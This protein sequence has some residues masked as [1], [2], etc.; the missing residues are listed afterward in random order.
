MVEAAEVGPRKVE[1]RQASGSF[2]AG[3]WLF[4]SSCLVL[5]GLHLPILVFG[6]GRP[7]DSSI[8]HEPAGEDGRQRDVFPLPLLEVSQDPVSSV[9]RSVQQRIHLKRQLALRANKA[10]F[11]VNLLFHG[12]NSFK[13][14]KPVRNLQT[15][16]LVQRDAILGIMEHVRDLGP[17]I[18]ACRSE[19][20]K[21]LRASEPPGY[22]VPD[23]SSGST[24]PM[25]LDALSLPSRGSAGVDLV[26]A[27]AEPVRSMVADFENYMLADS[28][29]WSPLTDSVNAMRPYNDPLLEQ[30]SSYLAFLTRLFKGGVLGFSD[31]CK[32]RVGAFCV[33][34]KPKVVDAVK[35][36]RQRLVLDCRQTNLLFK[37]PPQTHLGSL[38]SLA[39][40][41][42]ADGCTLHVAGADIRDCFYAVNMDQG[43]QQYFGLAFDISDDELFR[44]TGGVFTGGSGC[45]VPVIKVLPMGFSWSFYLV[46]QLHTENALNALGLDEKHLFLEGRPAPS[47]RDDNL[48][49]M[50]YC[51]NIHSICT[52]PSRCQE[53]KDSMVAA[54]EDIGFELHEHMEASPVFETL[55]GVI[56]G[57]K[58]KVSSTKKR[59]WQLIF[60]FET[61]SNIVV[62]AKTIQRLLGH[63]MV[64]SVL[65]RNGMSVFRKLYDFVAAEGP[66]RKLSPSERQECI[67][68][69]GIVPLLVANLRRPW[70]DII[71]CTDASPFGYG[72]CEQRVS[73]DLARSHGRWL[74]RWRFK[75]LP[76]SEWKPRIRSQGWDPLGDIRTVAGDVFPREDLEEEYIA[77]VDFPEI[78][79]HLMDPKLWSTVKLGKWAHTSEHI[80]LKEARALLLAVRRLSRNS[81]H[82]GRRHLFLVDNLA[83]CFSVA[84]GRAHSYD[85]LRVIQK[86]SAISLACQLTIRTRWVRS[87][88]NV[89]DGPS[90]GFIKPGAAPSCEQ[91]EVDIF[92]GESH[93][94]EASASSNWGSAEEFQGTQ[95]CSEV[96][97]SVNQ[98]NPCSNLSWSRPE[99]SYQGQKV[100]AGS[101]HPRF[102]GH[103]GSEEH[104][105]RV[106]DQ[107]REQREQQSVLHLLPQVRG[108]LEGER[109]P[110][111]TSQR[112]GR[113]GSSRLHGCAVLRQK[114][115]FSGRENFSCRRILQF[116]V[117][118]KHGTKQ[119]SF[120]GLEK[121]YA[122]SKSVAPPSCDDDGN[123]HEVG[124]KGF[125]GHGNHGDR[126]LRPLSPS[127]RGLEPEGQKCD[128]PSEICRGAIQAGHSGGEGFRDR[129]PR[130]GRRVRQFAENRQ[131]T[132]H[133]DWRVPSAEGQRGQRSRCHDFQLH[134]GEFEKGVCGSWKRF[135]G[136]PTSPLP[137]TPWWGVRGSKQWIPG[138]QLG[139]SPGSV[140]DG[141]EREK[142]CKN[143]KGAAAPY[144]TQPTE[145]PVLPLGGTKFGESFQ[146]SCP[147]KKFVTELDSNAVPDIFNLSP[148]PRH[149]TLEI[150]AG[151]A[152]LSQALRKVGVSC[153]PIDICLFPSHDVLDPQVEHSIRHF[154]CSHRVKFVWLGMPCTSFPE[155]VSLTVLDRDL[156]ALTNTSGVYLVWVVLMLVNFDKVTNY[157]CFPFAFFAFVI[158]CVSHL[159]LR[160][161]SHPWHGK[162]RQ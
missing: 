43:L 84:K 30:R 44:V 138:P 56:D 60:A 41:E 22:E 102:G 81:R 70:A 61:A 155:P 115:T 65:N 156:C 68:F 128:S 46:Q 154:L 117:Q 93:C 135:G 27:L 121:N 100:S 147:G 82:R 104:D 48:N 19:A 52:D 118:R 4:P 90:R 67:I 161:R 87:E 78:P 88:V 17:P 144:E 76:A 12:G 145:P 112:R 42:I 53:A 101:V 103:E 20:L 50:P 54:L 89:A 107:E 122:S 18:T 158:N 83:L 62:S 136:R 141:P 3:S 23:V 94:P 126:S 98:A 29:D 73:P 80:T 58:G 25:K 11:A 97:S 148:R 123:L 13:S 108:L 96:S 69:A 109:N 21:V 64:V 133:V 57:D 5:W 124:C 36:N 7:W 139:Q 26:G 129:G 149:F 159:S 71:S 15:L 160:T 131:P 8:F 91:P 10:I 137:V 143:R 49:I 34:K 105:D 66:P 16:P 59:M 72:V 85:M 35:I 33:A 110:L 99:E 119:K 77:N 150:F 55:G 151:T 47:L 113:P 114:D 146:G 14:P 127:W 51:D 152:R 31:G 116:G 153:F 132:H 2:A 9:C 79:D 130:Q 38:A 106:G 37:P 63:S 32:G 140:E 162:F 120:E 95:L 24:V 39:E 111:A 142:V 74:E 86:I 157:F 134:H 45:N 75:R 28:C 1:V 40:S 125:E 92:T 6:M